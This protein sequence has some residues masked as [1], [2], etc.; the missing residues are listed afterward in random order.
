[1]ALFMSSKTNAVY[2]IRKVKLFVF[3]GAFVQARQATSLTL[4][5]RDA[6]Y[7]MVIQPGTAPRVNAR[8]VGMPVCEDLPANSSK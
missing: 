2:P 1:M 8:Q 5:S 4:P 6:A 7:L 3:D